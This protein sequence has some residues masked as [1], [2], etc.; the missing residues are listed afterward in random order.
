MRDDDGTLTA[1]ERGDGHVTVRGAARVI[2]VLAV[3]VLVT[4]VIL[5]GNFVHTGTFLP[6]LSSPGQSDTALVDSAPEPEPTAGPDGADA[7]PQTPAARV[8]AE[9]A[10]LSAISVLSSDD[11]ALS[12]QWNTVVL[13]PRNGAQ[14]GYTAADLIAQG[15][16]RQDDST[17][18][19]LTSNVVVR[20]GAELDLSGA[21]STVR[22]A[23][24]AQATTSIVAWGGILG[25]GGTPDAPLVVTSWDES[26]NAADADESDGRAYI[27]VRDGVVDAT[28]TQ[29]RDLGYW[30]GR[31]GGLSVTGTGYGQAYAGLGGTTLSGLH[32][33]LFLSDTTGALIQDSRIEGSTLSGIE[34]T[35]AAADT[36]IERTTVTGSGGDGIAIS[37]QSKNVRVTGAAV[38]DS[39]GWGIR[40]DGAA[41][42]DGPTTGGYALTPSTGFTLSESRVRNSRDG[43]V[44][45]ISTD[46]T[47]ITRTTIDE[48]RTAVL[49]QGP[50]TGLAVTGVDLSSRELRGLEI[51]GDIAD[52][53]VSG[54]RLV[55]RRI[56][57]ELT[58]AAVIVRDNDLTVSSGYA[59]ELADAARAD[60]T[61][62]VFHGVGEDAVA[63]W[64]G[65]KTMQADNDQGDWR[66][67]WAWVGWMNEHPMMWMWGLVLLVPAIGMPVLWRR[68]AEHRRLRELLQEALLRHGQEQVAAYRGAAVPALAAGIPASADPPIAGK[69]QRPTDDG[70][71]DASRAGRGPGSWSARG[72]RP[73]TPA[74]RAGRPRPAGPAQ[75]GRPSSGRPRSFADLRTGVLEGRTFASLQ[76]FAVA[77]VLEGGY[78][79]STIA[80]LFRIQQW[81]LQKWVDEAAA[82]PR[83]RRG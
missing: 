32:Y 8:A 40:V 5:A 49:V 77:A 75:V 42:A 20:A 61:G 66:F 27:R 22:M 6:W 55:G 17:T 28:S 16:M 54:S 62:N 36:T 80:R 23:S 58:R 12:Q 9:D 81:R 59:V 74:E 63:S 7:A 73:G 14:T 48:A 10:R 50:S 43:G 30:S 72:T 37:R 11:P 71:E 52:A 3:I 29:F 83:V 64:S 25:F 57:L 4:G 60:I 33:G 19:T 41:L 15:A 68:R 44:R 39:A 35:N 78:S 38:E 26:A 51:A 31:T 45:V 47:E 65:A 13:A 67:Q 70:S 53:E 2:M 46:Q 82:A 18:F 1:E 21:G 79:V 24:S 76:D 56:A 69:P 34:V